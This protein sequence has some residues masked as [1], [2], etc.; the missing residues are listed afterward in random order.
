MTPS[1]FPCTQCGLCCQHVDLSNETQFLDRG[2]GTCRHYGEE[3]K[4]CTIYADRPSICRVDVQYKEKYYEKYSWDEF[5]A[6]NT[7]ACNAI[8]IIHFHPTRRL[9]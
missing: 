3:K 7:Q 6:I 2:D 5:V 4:I 8:E 9:G 1:E